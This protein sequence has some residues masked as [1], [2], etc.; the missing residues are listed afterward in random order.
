MDNVFKIKDWFYSLFKDK[1]LRRYIVGI[2]NDWMIDRNNND[3][4]I[5]QE[6][7]SMLK[8][9]QIKKCES[10]VALFFK[11]D[12]YEKTIVKQNKDLSESIL[13][14]YY[15]KKCLIELNGKV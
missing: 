5:Y 15:C 14:N 1:N 4:Y 8:K 12:I 9:D 11:E 2:H 13:K 3:G 10:C 7:Y 6:R